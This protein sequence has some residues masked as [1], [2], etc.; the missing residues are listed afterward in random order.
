MKTILTV[1]LTV[2]IVTCSFSQIKPLKRKAVIKES[3][4]KKNPRII[5]NDTLKNIRLKPSVINIAQR[6][7]KKTMIFPSAEEVIHNASPTFKYSLLGG[8]SGITKTIILTVVKLSDNPNWIAE[9]NIIL[10][11]EIESN[12][13]NT[14]TKNF[15][16]LSLELN[17]AYAWNIELKGET[18]IEDDMNWNVFYYFKKG[19]IISDEDP[20]VCNTKYIGNPSFKDKSYWKTTSTSFRTNTNT[21]TVSN[22][23]DDM[24]SGSILNP[25]TII[26]QKLQTPIRKDKNYQLKFSLNQKN[27]KSKFKIK[28]IAFNGTLNSLTPT[29]DIAIMTVSGTIPNKNDWS[30]ITLS[31][32]E[33]HK[34]FESIALIFMPENRKATINLLLDRVCLDEVE[35][36][37]DQNNLTFGIDNAQGD[38]SITVT[39]NEYWAGSVQ[40]LYPDQDTS[41]ADW[42]ANIADEECQSIG[43]EDSEDDQVVLNVQ[44]EQEIEEA[45]EELK[46]I[47]KELEKSAPK[48]F[49]PLNTITPIQQNEKDIKCSK[50]D[51]VLDNSKPFGGRDIIYIHGLQLQAILGN[52]KSTPTFQGKW[53]ENKNAFYKDGGIY[54]T[55]DVDQDGEYYNEAM[56]GHDGKPGYWENHIKRGLGSLTSPSNS[57]LIVTYS[58]NQRLDVSIHAVLT[59]I[60]EAMEGNNPNLQ[61]SKNALSTGECFGSNGIVVITHSTGGLLASTMFGIAEQSHTN[62]RLRDYYGDVRFITDKIDAQIGFDAAYGGSRLAEIGKNVLAKVTNNALLAQ[63]ATQYFTNNKVDLND[64][65]DITHLRQLDANG[66]ILTDLTPSVSANLWRPYMASTIPTLTMT[67]STIGNPHE[68]AVAKPMMTK[69]GNYFIK[70]YDDGVLSPV[71][72]ANSRNDFSRFKVKNR[73]KLVDKGHR[74]NKKDGVIHA[75]KQ[76][77]HSNIGTRNYYNT[78][79]LSP[80]GML[81][82]N[83]VARIIDPTNNHVPN[84]HTVLQTSGD[85]YDNVDLV[86]RYSQYSY[87][88]TKGSGSEG[89][90]INNEETGIV[91]NSALYSTGLLNRDF[92]GLNQE[93]IRN[94]KWGFH[95]PKITMVR[96]CIRLF[97]KE[98]C[99]K[100]PKISWHYYEYIKWQRK[101]HLLKDYETKIGM[102][103]MYEYILR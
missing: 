102:D 69:A 35:S 40:D 5:K 90:I 44:E 101:Y 24:G 51:R 100:L 85:H 21:N 84:H 43:G 19:I 22:G 91:F 25:N 71:S 2:F 68:S 97:R 59:Q 78:P 98:R 39:N 89:P 75:S 54:S 99:I 80:T 41:N 9:D 1:F 48:M 93:L 28:A 62:Q 15:S 45:N 30:K 94:E 37:C 88:K 36:A 6:Y 73:G 66:T 26:Y 23:H 58:A 79:Y 31:A 49:V 50:K 3:V 38:D 27:Q 57:F 53:P 95:A 29:S 70:G 64:Y 74:D 16:N 77:Q 76:G 67:G 12:L 10:Q 8:E 56:K 7:I 14:T 18:P 72:Q 13:N 42:Y 46:T 83:S 17:N 92:S 87:L 65:V 81:Q 32:W 4:I 11:E 20:H 82:G 52:L 55:G 63:L 60:K 103:Y 61:R 47:A 86:N 33:A 34:G 96:K